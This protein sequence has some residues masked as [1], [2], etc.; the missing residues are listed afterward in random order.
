MPRQQ[1]IWTA[2]PNGFDGEGASRTFRLSVFA[3]PRLRFDGGQ[4]TGTLEAFPDFLDW[5]ARVSA[6]VRFTLVVDA[7]QQEPRVAVPAAVV[8]A[9]AP[10]STLWKAMFGKDTL[11]RARTFEGLREPFASAPASTLAAGL[12]DG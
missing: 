2:L 8:T 6:G 10:D 12:A 5:P 3:A 4:E 1:I 7:L 9:H 11:V